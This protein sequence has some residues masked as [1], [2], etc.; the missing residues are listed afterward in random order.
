MTK[1]AIYLRI[2]TE[3]LDW[4]IKTSPD[5]Y[6]VTIHNILQNYKQDSA[7]FSRSLSNTGRSASGICVVTSW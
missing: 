1:K 3:L 2:D 7:G 5:W 4:L 6:Q